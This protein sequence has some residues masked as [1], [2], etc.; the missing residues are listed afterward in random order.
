MTKRLKHA[1]VGNTRKMP[2]KCLLIVYSDFYKLVCLYELVI[3]E[4]RCI[5]FDLKKYG[6]NVVNQHG[7]TALIAV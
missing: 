5:V 1:L 4:T 3:G 2:V 6:K 7:T